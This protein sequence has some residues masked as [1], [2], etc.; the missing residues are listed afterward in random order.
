MVLVCERHRDCPNR[1]I[2]SRTSSSPAVSCFSRSATRQAARRSVL[3]C[4]SSMASSCF[5]MSRPLMSIRPSAEQRSADRDHEH[6]HCA[7]D[8]L[9]IDLDAFGLSP[10]GSKPLRDP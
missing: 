8:A 9:A 10:I 4:K 7:G 1:V 6:D 5:P 3:A 2:R